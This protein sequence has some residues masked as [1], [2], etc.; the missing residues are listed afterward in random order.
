MTRI[1]ALAIAAPLVAAVAMGLFVL[2]AAVKQVDS[3]N[4]LE[5]RSAAQ[6]AS[7]LALEPAEDGGKQ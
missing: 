5:E 4:R 1:E 7:R 6:T 2:A 3:L